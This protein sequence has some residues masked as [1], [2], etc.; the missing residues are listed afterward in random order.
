MKA[1][2]SGLQRDHASV[3]A[4][5]S[6]A[7]VEAERALLDQDKDAAAILKAREAELAEARELVEESLQKLT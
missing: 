4:E 1:E 2:F 5:L 6:Q 7:R 3:T